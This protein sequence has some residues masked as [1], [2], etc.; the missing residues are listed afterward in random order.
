[1]EAFYWAAS[2]MMLVGPKG[3]NFY[4]IL[5]TSLTMFATVGIFAYIISSISNYLTIIKPVKKI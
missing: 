1:M 2:T 3:N 4:E 5:F